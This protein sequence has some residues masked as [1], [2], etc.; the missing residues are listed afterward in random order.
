[1]SEAQQLK[2][3]EHEPPQAISITDAGT[4]IAMI[5]RMTTDPNVDI[6]KFERL[7]ATYERIKETEAR[8]AFVAAFAAAKREI[9][10]AIR[11]AK[12]E[13]TGSK[14]ADLA[15]ISDADRAIRISDA[16]AATARDLF[17]PSS[18]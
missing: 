16:S 2:V 1:M 18:G 7:V 15:A 9:G 11:N 8:A 6:V 13:Q 4:L 14:Y 10:P 12:N 3:I 5:G 17:S